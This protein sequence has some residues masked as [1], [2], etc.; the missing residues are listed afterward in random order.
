MQPVLFNV[1][2]TAC[3]SYITVLVFRSAALFLLHFLVLF[4]FN[5]YYMYPRKFHIS[6]C[7][8]FVPVT[9]NFEEASAITSPGCSLSLP[10]CLDD[11]SNSSICCS[12][13][14]R[15]F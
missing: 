1:V 7:L 11:G 14:L 15:M 13:K 5:F 9:V 12:F 3:K 8:L 4:E 2:T 10:L 6:A